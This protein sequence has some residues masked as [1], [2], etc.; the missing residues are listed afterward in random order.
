MRLTTI[1]LNSILLRHSRKP[2]TPENQ[3]II[4]NAVR[5]ILQAVGED[6]QREG[7]AATPQRV[8]KMYGE[9]FA[10]LGTEPATHLDVTFNEDYDEM[11]VL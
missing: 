1:A 10:G 9:L 5:A 2:M 8:A 11:V 7:L 4:E 3:T 6:P